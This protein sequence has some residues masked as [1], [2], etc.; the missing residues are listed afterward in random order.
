MGV[1]SGPPGRV[2][3]IHHRMNELLI[4]QNTVS[5]GEVTSIQERA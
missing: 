4:K 3:I 1:S 2:Y 5:G